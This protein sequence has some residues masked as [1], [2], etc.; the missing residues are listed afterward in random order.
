[1]AKKEKQAE[2]PK[3]ETKGLSELELI[4]VDPKLAVEKS[5]EYLKK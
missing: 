5:T 3:T 2:K 1:M 4:N